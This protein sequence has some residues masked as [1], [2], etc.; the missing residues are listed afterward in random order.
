MATVF[1]DDGRRVYAHEVLTYS[2]G[3]FQVDL[4]GF[5]G[6]LQET[7]PADEII[8]DRRNSVQRR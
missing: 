3:P 7:E 5:I 4:E 8:L 6:V 1:L 2:E